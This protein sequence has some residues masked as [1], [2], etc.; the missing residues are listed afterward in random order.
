MRVDQLD[1]D[2]VS[3]SDA[4]MWQEILDLTNLSEMPPE[5]ALQPMAS[6]R[7]KMAESLSAA[8]RHAMEFKRSTGGRNVMRRMTAYEYSNTLRD[9]LD[10]DLRFMVDLPQKVLRKRV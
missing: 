9:L 10:L 2:L 8:L 1:P 3:G 7:S 6:E 4:D 5:E